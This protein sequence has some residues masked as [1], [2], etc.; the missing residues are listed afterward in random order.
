MRNF[1]I[2]LAGFQSTWWSRVYSS[3]IPNQ[4]RNWRGQSF[5]K[6]T[7]IENPSS[8]SFSI[9][10]LGKSYFGTPASWYILVGGWNSCILHPN[11]V[12]HVKTVFPQYLGFPQGNS[13]S[14]SSRCSVYQ[15][16]SPFF[17]LLIWLVLS[18]IL[19]VWSVEWRNKHH[20]RNKAPHN[21]QSTSMTS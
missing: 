18:A 17:Y 19:H 11:I 4:S 13:Y 9:T 12:S 7:V 5:V 16:L 20:I 8:K 1:R 21:E 6:S 14:I 15:R 10:F 2:W 3:Q